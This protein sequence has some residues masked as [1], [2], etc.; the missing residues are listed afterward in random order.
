MS[1]GSFLQ[2][3]ASHLSRPMSHLKSSHPHHDDMHLTMSLHMRVLHVLLT[4]MTVLSLYVR[5][6]HSLI[7]WMRIMGLCIIA[8]SIIFMLFF[9]LELSGLELLPHFGAFSTVAVML[10]S[11]R[12]FSPHCSA[13]LYCL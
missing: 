8:L 10:G 12:C 9:M 5:S 13:R 6:L 11:S 4:L 7:L 3:G 2:H 1:N